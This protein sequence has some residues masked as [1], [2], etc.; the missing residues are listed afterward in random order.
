M[1]QLGRLR[2]LDRGSANG[3]FRRILPVPPRSGGGRLNE[4]TPAVQPRQRELV[5]VPHTGPS[6]QRPQTA[7]WG[8]TW[9]FDRS[10]ANGRLAQR[11]QRPIP[12][13]CRGAELGNRP[14]AGCR[15]VQSSIWLSHRLPGCGPTSGAQSTALSQRGGSIC[16]RPSGAADCRQFEQYAPKNS[17]ARAAHF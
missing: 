3:R 17:A 7:P 6:R 16:L 13:Q 10:R 5:K 14:A 4:R 8:R 9:Q 2:R 11:R 1:S 15:A 12:L